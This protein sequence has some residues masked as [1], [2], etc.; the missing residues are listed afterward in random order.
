[1]NE[2]EYEQLILKRD[3]ERLAELDEIKKAKVQGAR[4]IISAFIE[5][6][7]GTAAWRGYSKDTEYVLKGIKEF[8]FKALKDL[9]AGNEYLG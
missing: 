8:L 5:K 6:A 4:I 1:M 2:Q 3:Q 9:E 7:W